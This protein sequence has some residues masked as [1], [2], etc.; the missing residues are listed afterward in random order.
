VAP[1]SVAQEEATALEEM[2]ISGDFFL[3]FPKAGR[4]CHLNISSVQVCC[5]LP[6]QPNSRRNRVKGQGAFDLQKAVTR[7]AFHLDSYLRVGVS[8]RD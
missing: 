2:Q 5:E 6:Q 7:L 4:F 3:Y 8:A 1:V